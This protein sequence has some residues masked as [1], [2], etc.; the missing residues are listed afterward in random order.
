MLE[1]ILK[2]LTLFF[3]V[4]FVWLFTGGAERGEERRALNEDSLFIGITGTA[5]DSANPGEDL[6]KILPIEQSE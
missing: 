6:K 4:Y 5:L 2:V 3:F 1:F